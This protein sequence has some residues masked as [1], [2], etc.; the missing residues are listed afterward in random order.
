[1]LLYII[2]RIV[3]YCLKLYIYLNII[4]NVYI[5]TIQITNYMDSK[6]DDLHV[7]LRMTKFISTSLISICF[8]NIIYEYYSIPKD[9]HEYYSIP[10]DIHEYYSIPKDIHEYYSIPKDIH[11][12]YSIPKDIHEYYSTPKDIPLVYLYMYVL[13]VLR[14]TF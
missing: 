14:V 10:K 4:Y 5:L 2:C 8:D 12:Y 9:I 6:F 13:L 7:I 11:E 3:I 1:M